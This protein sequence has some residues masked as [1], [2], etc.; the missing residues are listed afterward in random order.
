MRKR[1]EEYQAELDHIVKTLFLRRDSDRLPPLIKDQRIRK[2]LDLVSL[3]TH[4]M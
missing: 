2:V 4:D 1:K 3:S